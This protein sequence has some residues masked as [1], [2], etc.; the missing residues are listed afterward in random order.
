MAAT[1]Q[2][3]LEGLSGSPGYMLLDGLSAA[4]VGAETPGDRTLDIEFYN[5]TMDIDESVRTM[6]IES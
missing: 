2:L 4:T 6:D 5:R 3:L 1:V